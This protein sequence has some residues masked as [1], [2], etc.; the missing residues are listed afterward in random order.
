MTW[1]TRHGLWL[2]CAAPLLAQIIGSAFNISYNLIHTEPLLTEAQHA[3]FAHA[4][5]VY[6]VAVYPVLSAIWIR[7]VF[8]LRH[9]FQQALRGR[10][11]AAQEE[12]QRRVINLPWWLGGVASTGWLLC[13]PV[14][15]WA[16]ARVREPLQ[17]AVF[18]H[19]PISLVIAAMIAV[20]QGF[21]ATELLSQWLLFPVFF[22]G[23]RAAETPGAFPLSLRGRGVMWA[24]SAGACP[25]ASLLLLI[26]APGPNTWQ[27]TWFALA[28]GGLGIAS[29]LSC[30]WLVGRVVVEPLDALR[31]AAQ[32]VATGDLSAHIDLPRADEFGPLIDEFNAMVGELRD[33]ERLQETFGHHV[34]EQA[35]REILRRDPGLG[36]IEQDLTVLFTDIRDFTARSEASEPQRVVAVLNLFLTEMVGVIEGRHGGMVNKFLGDGFM[37]LFGTGERRDDHAAR[38]VAAGLEMLERLQHVNRRLEEQGQPALAIGIGIHT[39]PAVVGSIGSPQR[40]EYTA[41]GDTVNVASRV[42]S[43]TKLVGVPLLV[44]AATRAGLPATTRVAE[45]PPQCVKGQLKPLIVYGICT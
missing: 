24:I 28:V 13:I 21:F 12:T 19:L 43:L 34:G 15:L 1:T 22:R 37:A 2:V 23:A 18:Y 26:V 33:K 30:A 29:A 7:A 45:L 11:L 44:T 25:I 9:P 6:N 5:V 38:A 27:N 3:A 39:G 8:L 32:S 14:F 41:I 4:I 20:T 35:A 10:L 17:P 36:G 16:V 31:R 42:E 40:L